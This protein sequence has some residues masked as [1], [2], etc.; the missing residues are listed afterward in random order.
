[1]LDNTNMGGGDGRPKYSHIL[2]S[3]LLR[4]TSWVKRKL[5]AGK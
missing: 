4:I 2:H 1:M 3:S 5:K